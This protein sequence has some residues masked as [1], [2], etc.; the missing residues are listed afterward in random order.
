MGFPGGSVGKESACKG[1]MDSIRGLG[2][3]S[4]GGKWQP[5]PAVLPEKSHGQSSLEGY[6]PWDYK[7]LD[8]TE[9]LRAH[10]NMR[11]VCLL[12]DVFCYILYPFLEVLFFFP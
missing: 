6:S 4:E 5:T 3:F 11:C 10:Q 8:M 12:V 1:D 7:D 2:R 9:R